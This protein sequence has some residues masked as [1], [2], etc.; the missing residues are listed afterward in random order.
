[1]LDEAPCS[2]LPTDIVGRAIVDLLL[3]L[4]GICSVES[5]AQ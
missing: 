5:A 1:V 3:Y 4:H 2:S